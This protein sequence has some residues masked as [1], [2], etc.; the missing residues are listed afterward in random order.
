MI[1]AFS[2]WWTWRPLGDFVLSVFFAALLR[3][4]SQWQKIIFI[5][6]FENG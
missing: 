1:I 6:F 3:Y 5:I 4:S 2:S